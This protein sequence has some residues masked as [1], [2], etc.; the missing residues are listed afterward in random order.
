MWVIAFSYMPRRLVAK[1]TCKYGSLLSEHAKTFRGKY[2]CKY[3]SYKSIGH[4]QRRALF[5]GITW[6]EVQSAGV[7]AINGPT[8]LCHVMPER[9]LVMQISRLYYITSLV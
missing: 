1:Y 6:R 5:S 8:G 3:A 9:G 4:Q 7:Q 2:A